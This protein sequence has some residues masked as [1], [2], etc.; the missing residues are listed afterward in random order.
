VLRSLVRAGI[1][2]EPPLPADP[3]EALAVAYSHPPWLVR[4]LVKAWGE[5]ETEAWL[6]AAQEPAPPVI[7]ANT[8][9]TAGA[10]LAQKL[11]PACEKI[12]PHELSPDALVLHGVSGPLNKLPGYDQGLWQAQDPG[13][14]LMARLL[15]PLPGQRV[16]DLCAGAGGK[17]SHLAALM[18][19]QGELWAVD[20]SPGRLAALKQ[21]LA[22]L[23]V[24]IARIKQADARWFDGEMGPFDRILVDAPCSGL[25]TL[26]RRPDIRWRVGPKD[27]AKLS[28]L[29][30]ALLDR[31]VELLRPGG[32]LLYCTCT[33]TAEENQEVV[34]KLLAAQPGLRP[35]W[36]LAAA[37]LPSEQGYVELLAHHHHCDSFF[38]ARLVKVG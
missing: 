4:R 20:N 3:A 35:D 13:S 34:G 24:K 11:A 21:N 37:D 5:A 26:G 14:Q 27:P 23:G 28:G 25:G 10:D 33:V 7:R 6:T 31:A 9:K 2:E 36:T 19:N 8:L 18:E 16:L 32:A 30:S 29:Q 15:A 17:T 22:R 38:A 12:M 1:E